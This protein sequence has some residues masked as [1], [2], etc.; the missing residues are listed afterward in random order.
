MAAPPNGTVSKAARTAGPSLA[1][2][3]RFMLFF[4]SL[5]MTMEIAL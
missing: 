4:P 2:M 5:E 1:L 3:K